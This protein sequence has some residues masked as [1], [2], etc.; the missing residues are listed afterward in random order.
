MLPMRISMGFAFMDILPICMGC[1]GC[2]GGI[3]CM[4]GIGSMGCM[5]DDGDGET[6]WLLCWPL[7][8]VA[9]VEKFMGCMG[10]MGCLISSGIAL[11]VWVGRG[12]A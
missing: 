8:A 1:I 2:I 10:C 7:L 4:G 3:G 12:W 5:G 11:T 9:P 6:L